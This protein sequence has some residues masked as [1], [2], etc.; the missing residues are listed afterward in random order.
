MSTH[1]TD[2]V[3]EM[4]RVAC[5]MEAAA[6][7]PGNVHPGAAFVDMSYDDLVVS[8]SVIAPVLSRASQQGLGTTVLDAVTATHEA[9]GCNTNLGI[10]LLL[11]PLAAVPLDRSLGD[12][13]SDVLQELTPRDTRQVY[14]AIRLA[15]PGGLGHVS[16][17]D[18]LEPPGDSLLAAMQ[19]AADRDAVASCYVDRF[20]RLLAWSRLWLP[21][22]TDFARNWSE[23]IV[24]LAL[25]VLAEQ[26]DSLIAR[27]CGVEVAEEASRRAREVL[28]AGWPT[29]SENGP[30]LE[31]FDTWLRTDGHQRNPG[32]T[33]DLV[34]ATLFSALRERRI[35]AP[36][37]DA[38]PVTSIL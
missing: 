38:L 15:N 8:A 30:T 31:S 7:K 9:V 27:K 29:Q 22:T 20:E 35:I 2:S 4:V 18:I 12:G 24:G 10:I 34:T 3:G 16:Q 21:A 26:A 13:V 37:L 32:T 11:T 28:E 33:A 14:E 19:L 36:P 23:H 17:Q 5:L 6:P 1:S 25:R